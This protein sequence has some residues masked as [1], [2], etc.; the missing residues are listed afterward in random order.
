M[1]KSELKKV[2]RLIQ[3]H[4]PSGWAAADLLVYRLPLN[5]V[6]RGVVFSSS[7]RGSPLIE[8]SLFARPLYVPFEGLF[9]GPSRFVR[10]SRFSFSDNWPEEVVRESPD[11]VVKAIVRCCPTNLDEISTPLLLSRNIWSVFRK[12]GMQLDDLVV[13]LSLARGGSITQAKVVLRKILNRR[14]SERDRVPGVV[15]NAREAW[16]V[17]DNPSELQRLLDH[18]EEQTRSQFK[19]VGVRIPEADSRWQDPNKSC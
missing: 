3:G 14:V 5:S 9:V 12:P 10:R 7:L 4:L 6:L 16:D 1:K 11:S 15:E 18:W 13:A 19:E 17:I 8:I 2:V